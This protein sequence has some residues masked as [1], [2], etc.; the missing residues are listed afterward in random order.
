MQLYQQQTAT[1]RRQLQG[2]GVVLLSRIAR[3]GECMMQ[4]SSS[5]SLLPP[6]TSRVHVL[7]LAMLRPP[8][9]MSTL[10]TLPAWL[11]SSCYI[12]A[13]AAYCYRFCYIVIVVTNTRHAAAAIWNVHLGDL[14]SLAEQL[15]IMMLQA[16]LVSYHFC[17]YQCYWLCCDCHSPCCGRRQGY[18]PWS[19]PLPG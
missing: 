19:P 6:D 9:G 16:K 11:N 1:K 12:T 10:V 3:A 13:T 2:R 7:S 8:S 14:A 15:P 5:S 18:P 17:C 4:L